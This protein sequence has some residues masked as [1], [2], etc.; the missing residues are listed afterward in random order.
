MHPNISLGMHLSPLFSSHYSQFLPINTMHTFSPFYAPRFQIDFKQEFNV[1]LLSTLPSIRNGHLQAS[2]CFSSYLSSSSPFCWCRSSP[3]PTGTSFTSK[4]LLNLLFINLQLELK[5]YVVS[6]VQVNSNLAATYP[7]KK[8]GKYITSCYIW[9]NWPNWYMLI[10]YMV[11][12][13][14]RLW[15][16]MHCKVPV[17]V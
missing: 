7:P 17:I 8:I 12:W 6:L 10:W 14:F 1:S 11:Y 15:K 13:N 5:R 4:Y 9:S 2:D 3:S 16:R